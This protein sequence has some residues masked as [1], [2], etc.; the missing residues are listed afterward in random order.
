M[1]TNEKASYRNKKLE[2]AITGIIALAAVCI[3]A[4]GIWL[5]RQYREGKA[6]PQPVRTIQR[7]DVLAKSKT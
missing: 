3:F 1:D 2:Y 6:A 5:L 7:D 4:A